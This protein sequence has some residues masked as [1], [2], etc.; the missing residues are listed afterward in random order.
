MSIG[1]CSVF[2]VL[3]E[4]QA[5]HP[6]LC[7]RTLVALLNILQGQSPEGL[8]SEPADIVGKSHNW[9]PTRLRLSVVCINEC[10][11]LVKL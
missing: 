2:E 6:A 4:T 8:R 5:S 7:H 11:E 10:E 9:L 3:R 1:L